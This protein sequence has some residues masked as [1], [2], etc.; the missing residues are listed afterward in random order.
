MDIQ[1]CKNHFDTIFSKKSNKLFVYFL[2]S[3]IGKPKVYKFDTNYHGS[4]ITWLNDNLCAHMYEKSD[5]F[6]ALHCCERVNKKRK[7]REENG[8]KKGKIK[9]GPG[10]KSR[11]NQNKNLDPTPPK[12]SGSDLKRR[13]ICIQRYNR[14]ITSINGIT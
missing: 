6:R 12:K 10:K 13:W 5:P 1:Y 2:I 7:E 11:T 14:N 4:L 9:T 3:R 8:S